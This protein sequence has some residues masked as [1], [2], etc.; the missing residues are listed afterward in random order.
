MENFGCGNGAWT[1]VMKIDGNK[2][3][4][5]LWC[6]ESYDSNIRFLREMKSLENVEFQIIVFF[7]IFNVIDL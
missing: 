5:E 3:I 4:T 7:F 1:S 2:V 6:V